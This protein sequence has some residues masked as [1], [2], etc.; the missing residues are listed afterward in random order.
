MNES[1]ENWVK[2]GF[3][4]KHQTS[5]REIHDLLDVARRDLADCQ[6]EGLSADWKLNIAH[7]AA[8]QIAA[9]A[10]HVCGYTATRSAHHY[11]TIQSLEHTLKL[12]KSQ[13]QLFETFHK[14]RN[15]SGYDRV[16]MISD[17]EAEEM[18]LF[19]QTLLKTF[20][21]WRSPEQPNVEL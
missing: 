5:A 10:L 20:L 2:F 7:N 13:V 11:R 19:A 1:L 18:R 17:Q 8:L 14:K 9:A 16:G 21:D 3:L 4:K 15:V 12:S 6:S